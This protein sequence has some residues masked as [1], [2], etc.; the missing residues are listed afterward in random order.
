MG[1]DDKALKYL[2]DNHLTLDDV[3][4]MAKALKTGNPTPKK[5]YSVG[6]MSVR[7]LALSDTHIGSIYYDKDLMSFAVGQAKKEACDF[8]IHAGDVLEGWF[9]NRPQSIFELNAVGVDQQ[10]GMGVEELCKL[11]C[12]LYF[13]TGNHEYNTFMRGAGIEVGRVLEEKAALKGKTHHFL[14]NAEGDISLKGGATIKLLHPDSVSS[15]AISYRSQ[16]IAESLEGGKKPS[17]LHIGN[18]HKAEYLF[19]RNIHIIQTACL[20]N[21]TKFMRGRHIAAMKGF[22]IVDLHSNSLGGVELI[23]PRFYPAYD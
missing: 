18:M 1:K 12:P 4:V 20:Q 14:G 15:Y 10:V 11:P 2:K 9:Q 22:Y 6:K 3:V 5:Q 8:A 23:V 16:K 21:Q 13:I 17:V 7:Y 19:Y